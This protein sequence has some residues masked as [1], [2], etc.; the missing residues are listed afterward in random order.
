MIYILILL[1]HVVGD[2]TFQSKGLAKAKDKNVKYLLVHLLIY[3]I[4]MIL[5]LMMLGK[6][7]IVILY[8]FVVLIS[9]FIID[10][11]KSKLSKKYFNAFS[12]SLFFVIDQ[13]LHVLILL[14]IAYWGFKGNA[15]Y[16][17]FTKGFISA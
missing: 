15:V 11:L 3:M 5:V 7:R 17:W 8:F 4:P 6:V 1:V 2:F 13:C 12:H 9:H 16:D 14:A 10:L